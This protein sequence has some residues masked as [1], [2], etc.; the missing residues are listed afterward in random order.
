MN[1]SQTTDQYVYGG[2]HTVH[3]V[4]MVCTSLE[5]LLTMCCFFLQM[6]MSVQ[7]PQPAL[8]A[9]VSILLVVT[10]VSALLILSWIPPV[11]DVLVRDHSLCWLWHC[12]EELKDWL[13]RN[14]V[15]VMERGWNRLSSSGLEVVTVQWEYVQSDVACQKHPAAKTNSFRLATAVHSWQ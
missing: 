15:P 12:V 14:R 2:Q 13:L 10:P 1:S 5:Y 6:L 11:L 4:P 7:T 9:H 3:N 8:V